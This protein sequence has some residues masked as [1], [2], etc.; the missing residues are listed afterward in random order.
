MK[1]F[2]KSVFRFV[3]NVQPIE[4][5]F[6]KNIRWYQKFLWHSARAIRNC[7]V[8]ASFVITGYASVA[9]YEMFRSEPARAQS[10]IEIPAKSE[11][12]PILQRI[13]NAEVTGNPNTPSHQFNKNGSVVRG[14]TTPS[15]IGYCQINEPI[16]NDKARELG[17]DIYTEEGN[18][19][20]AVWLFNHYGSEPW[21]ISKN[22]WKR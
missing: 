18:K 13:C 1:Q 9:I 8:V 22:N 3:Y 15:D 12:P 17:Y 19:A 16:W 5:Y 10:I 7:S 2:I 20:F 6:S 11:F 21:Y 14:K 4:T